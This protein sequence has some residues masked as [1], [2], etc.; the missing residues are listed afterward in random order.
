MAAPSE[1]A[2]GPVAA[3]TRPAVFLPQDI[4]RFRSEYR[5]SPVGSKQASK[6]VKTLRR[7]ATGEWKEG[8]YEVSCNF[9][10]TNAAPHVF[11]WRAWIAK[12]LH[13]TTTVV[14]P[15]IE[16]VMLCFFNEFDANHSQ[17]RFDYVI[18]RTDGIAHRLHPHASGRED[19]ILRR[20]ANEWLQVPKAEEG[21]DADNVDLAPATHRRITLGKAVA[22]YTG[23]RWD[24]D[25]AWEPA[26]QPD[27]MLNLPVRVPDGSDGGAPGPADNTGS[28][29]VQEP[30]ASQPPPPPPPRLPAP[31][32]PLAVAPMEA[33]PAPE[34]QSMLLQQRTSDLEH[35]VVPNTEPAPASSLRQPGGAPELA[36]D[37]PP[38]QPATT[39]PPG[40]AQGPAAHR[41]PP[42]GEVNS[43]NTAP[44]GGAQGPAVNSSQPP[45]TTAPPG[46]W[47]QPHSGQPTWQPNRGRRHNWRDVGAGWSD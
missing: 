40:G 12:R 24:P 15:G 26:C 5:S 46:Q 18:F 31:P 38:T 32:L 36:A 11:N 14:G 28:P 3:A 22:N 16:R 43:Y 13:G 4:D 10:L 41:Q 23:R 21:E 33:P 17:A 42:M 47:Q 35:M 39:A 19:L 27:G 34:R 29:V 2:T 9:D 6:Y 37:P 25:N 45:I 20:V 1:D 7:Q 44:E 8:Y 30:A